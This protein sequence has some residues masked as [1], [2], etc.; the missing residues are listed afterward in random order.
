MTTKKF[1]LTVDDLDMQELIEAL[2]PFVKLAESAP[3][4][5]DDR[6]VACLNDADVVLTML[7]LRRAKTLLDK[8]LGK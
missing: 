6:V 1:G 5:L 2:E 7:D 4:V 3:S 8:I